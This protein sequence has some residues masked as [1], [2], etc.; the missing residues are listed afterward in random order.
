MTRP[1]R[2]IVLLHG[3]GAR[4]RDLGPL[5]RS[6]TAAHPAVT[7]YAERQKR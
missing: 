6:L 7:F 3:Y 5:A 2:N 1:L 4:G